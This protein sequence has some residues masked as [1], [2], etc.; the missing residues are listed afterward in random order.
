MELNQIILLVVLALSLG[1]LWYFLR[2]AILKVGEPYD[3]MRKKMEEIR[4]T[5]DAEVRSGEYSEERLSSTI[6][7]FDGV[8]K[9]LRMPEF[10]RKHK[11]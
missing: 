1:L 5:L 11:S 8:A 10:S 2:R 6:A 3:T 4:C 7:H 9:R